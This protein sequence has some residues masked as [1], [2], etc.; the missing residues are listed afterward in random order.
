LYEKPNEEGH[1]EDL[2][3]DG[4]AIL[5]WISGNMTEARGFDK[6]RSE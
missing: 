6:C 5:N 3:I 2:G 4:R 1:L